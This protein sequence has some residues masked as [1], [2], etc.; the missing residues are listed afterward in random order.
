MSLAKNSPEG[1]GGQG[2]LSWG[3]PGLW[4]ELMPHSY[5]CWTHL[6]TGLSL[7]THAG[8]RLCWALGT[9]ILKRRSPW[10]HTPVHEPLRMQRWVIRIK[11]IHVRV[12]QRLTLRKPTGTLYLPAASGKLCGEIKALGATSRAV[13]FVELLLFI[14]LIKLTEAF[15][16][17]Q[18]QGAQ[19]GKKSGQSCV[20]IQ[21]CPSTFCSPGHRRQHLWAWCFSVPLPEHE[22]SPS[23]AVLLG[24]WSESNVAKLTTKVC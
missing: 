16:R 1:P 17:N 4:L 11:I 24:G 15:H 13:L 5:L 18:R 19:K 2:H 3:L 23:P 22:D 12:Q 21:V 8:S 6:F 10:P 7:S 9:Q 20:W 14:C